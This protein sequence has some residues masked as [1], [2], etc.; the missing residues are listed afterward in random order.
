[1]QAPERSPQAYP[2]AM[3]LVWRGRLP[4]RKEATA[5]A[6]LGELGERQQLVTSTPTEAP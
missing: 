2:C 1:V 3:F 4:S 5:E 6:E